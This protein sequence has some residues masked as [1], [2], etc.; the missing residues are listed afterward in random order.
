MDYFTECEHTISQALAPQG[1]DSQGYGSGIAC[2]A[3]HVR[4]KIAIFLYITV[5]NWESMFLAVSPIYIAF[6]HPIM[7]FLIIENL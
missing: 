6:F 7:L 4:G 3:F 5:I 2:K 1:S